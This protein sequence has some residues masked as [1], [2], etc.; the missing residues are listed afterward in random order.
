MEKIKLTIDNRQVEVDKGTTLVEAAASIG[1]KIPTLCHLNLH[2]LNYENNP[3]A[4]RICVVEVAGRRNLAPA[5]KTECTEG[6]EVKTHSPRVINA[7]QTVMELILSNHPNECLTCAKNGA[8]DLQSIA[9]D[10]GIRKINYQGEMSTFTP[11]VSL[12]IIRNM[13]KCIMCRRCETACNSIQSVG[14]LSA[15]SRGFEAVVGTA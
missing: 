10:L 7:R 2:D 4:C 15:T 14:A 9:S 3:G 8:C 11:D 1:I 5:C 12:S 6:M 13:D